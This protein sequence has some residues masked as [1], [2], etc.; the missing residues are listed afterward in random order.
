ML[1]ISAGQGSSSGGQ[2]SHV[3]LPPENER[4]DYTLTANTKLHW[5]RYLLDKTG[6]EFS[7]LKQFVEDHLNKIFKDVAGF[8][9]TDVTEFIEDKVTFKA[10]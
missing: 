8:L 5:V 6:P 1:Q 4:R 2:T 9:K 3:I 7:V 10:T